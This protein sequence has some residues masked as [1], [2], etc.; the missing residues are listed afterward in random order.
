MAVWQRGGCEVIVSVIVK[1]ARPRIVTSERDERG[2]WGSR[3]E[4]EVTCELRHGRDSAVSP[5]SDAASI[6]YTPSEI[7]RR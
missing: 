7:E 2:R 5:F 6:Y 4:R 3:K 1:R